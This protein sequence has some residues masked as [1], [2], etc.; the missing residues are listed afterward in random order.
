MHCPNCGAHVNEQDQYC[1]SCG[2]SLQTR[3]GRRKKQSRLWLILSLALIVIVGALIGYYV[4]D[5]ST[6][7][8]ASNHVI[9]HVEKP[10]PKVKKQAHK[11]N[12]HHSQSLK[13]I[14]QKSQKQVVQVIS[15]TYEGDIL[16]SGFLY[17]DKG[18]V[19]TNAHVVSG[20]LTVT[21]KTSD[22]QLFNGNVIGVGDT[23]D[24]AVVRV[25]EL[26][27]RTPLKITDNQKVD[28]G[29]KIIALGSPL[30]LQ[31]T[32]TTGIISGINRDFSIGPFSYQNVYQITA[33]IAHGNSGG[34]LLDQKTGKVLAINSAGASE[35]N[36]GFSIPIQNVLRD[37][38][39]WS[40]HPEPMTGSNGSTPPDSENEQPSVQDAENL[41]RN[42]YE[43]INARDY[44]AAYNMLG[45][46]WQ[47]KTTFQDF[48]NGFSQTLYD[49]IDQLEGSVSGQT[50]T[51]TVFFE[52][53]DQIDDSDIKTT[54][55]KTTYKV[56]FE[57][58][59]LKIL[60]GKGEK[61]Q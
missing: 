3:V 21:V 4:Y 15:Q 56:G 6:A 27:N 38:Q 26:A 14:I 41:L 46:H 20:A 9:R 7:K 28:V 12:H 33:P 44:I 10:T 59:Q 36:I 43:N 22:Q 49:E 35:G 58:N 40:E 53:T 51:V 54:S 25:P 60:S 31:N 5:Q 45:S 18:D 30:G 24:V 42:F 57:N 1:V 52:A 13:D 39:S 16:G 17:N 11:P 55:Y 47:E 61:L 48:Q 32:V 2:A 8:I 19:V 23:K 29:D 34:P 37:I 50:V